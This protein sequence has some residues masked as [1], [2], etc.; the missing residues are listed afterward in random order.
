MFNLLVVSTLWHI[1]GISL[2]FCCLLIASHSLKAGRIRKFSELVLLSIPNHLKWHASGKMFGKN[3]YH[4]KTFLFPSSFRKFIEPSSEKRMECPR[5][6]NENPRARR[7]SHGI[8]YLY[9]EL[10]RYVLRCCK[11]WMAHSRI[12]NNLFTD[13]VP[14]IPWV[15]LLPILAIVI[16]IKCFSSIVCVVVNVLSSSTHRS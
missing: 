2:L 14:S 9:Y 1:P 16:R 15:R 3:F 13:V 5:V 8:I 6:N 10:Q 7:F 4:G 11:V 12:R